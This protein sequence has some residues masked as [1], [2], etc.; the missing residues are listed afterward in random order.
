METSSQQPKKKRRTPAEALAR[1]RATLTNYVDAN[2]P[3]VPFE[4]DDEARA[5]YWVGLYEMWGSHV[6][7]ALNIVLDHY[8]E[9]GH[10]HRM[11]GQVKDG[12]L[13]TWR[14]DGHNI[15]LHWHPRLDC[16]TIARYPIVNA[17]RYGFD[18]IQINA[19]A[20]VPVSEIM[21][22]PEVPAKERGGYERQIQLVGLDK[23]GSRREARRG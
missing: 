18:A 4:L 2:C 1:R 14:A 12:I 5:A 17:A 22:W 19:R 15:S 16:Y 3:G 7:C 11:I 9:S 6:E 20:V 13:D 23:G 21:E 10:R 8:P